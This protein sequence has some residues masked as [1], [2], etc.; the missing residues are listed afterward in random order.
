MAS[1]IDLIGNTPIIKLQK[2]IP[3]NSGSVYV[4]L[5]ALNIFKTVTEIIV[6]LE[7]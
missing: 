6:F 7:A 2:I 3:P 1:I 4:K 5:E